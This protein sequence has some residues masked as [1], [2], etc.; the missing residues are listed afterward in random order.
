ME[1]E[2]GRGMETKGERSVQTDCGKGMEAEGVS[3]L[4]RCGRGTETRG[5]ARMAVQGGGAWKRGAGQR[6][7]RVLK[8]KTEDNAQARVSYQSLPLPGYS[9]GDNNT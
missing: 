5:G 7:S 3:T 1:A 8:S 6:G 2:G 9:T 4:R